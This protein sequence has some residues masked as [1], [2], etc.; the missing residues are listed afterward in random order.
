MEDWFQDNCRISL[1]SQVEGNYNRQSFRKQTIMFEYNR[2]RP[3]ARYV[4]KMDDNAQIDFHQLKVSLEQSKAYSSDMDIL[5]PSPARN[6]KPYP[7]STWLGYDTVAGKWST[8][9]H[10]FTGRT[11]P[12]F[13]L[14]FLYVLSPKLAGILARQTGNLKWGRKMIRLEDIF[15]TG[16]VRNQTKSSSKVLERS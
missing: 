15:L 11:Y 16:I 5:C 12:D 14:G 13:C 4:M 2:F 1:G 3:D 6:V 8:K 10:E 9:T 7:Y